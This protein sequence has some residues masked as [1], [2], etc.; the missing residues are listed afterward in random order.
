MKSGGH[1][2]TREQSGVI[3][4]RVEVWR[5]SSMS[6][7][8]VGKERACEE[9]AGEGVVVQVKSAGCVL[10]GSGVG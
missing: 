1:S 8:E 2:I 7:S 6:E 5:R 3:G 9:V 4:V 10:E